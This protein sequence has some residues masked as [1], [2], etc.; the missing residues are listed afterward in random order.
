MRCILPS[1]AERR[2]L[3]PRSLGD[4]IGCGA[5]VSQ[6]Q[7]DLS[8]LSNAL[9]SSVGLCDPNRT[10]ARR[11][12][13]CRGLPSIIGCAGRATGAAKAIDDDARAAG[14][15]E[16]PVASLCETSV[17]SSSFDSLG[18]AWR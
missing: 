11:C 14:G 12:R 15:E 9:S 16:E 6:R 7:A 5:C 17:C 10:F 8:A 3:A 13:R 2:R 4:G 1:S 18:S